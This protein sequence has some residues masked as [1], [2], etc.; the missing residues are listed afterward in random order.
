MA[1]RRK[2]LEYYLGRIPRDKTEFYFDNVVEAV[3]A[4]RTWKKSVVEFY[5]GNEK[6]KKEDPDVYNYLIK[7]ELTEEEIQMITVEYHKEKY[8]IFSKG[9]NTE[10]YELD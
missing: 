7:P 4:Y 1:K 5:T 3:E 9:L 6:V 8:L 10:E 2:S